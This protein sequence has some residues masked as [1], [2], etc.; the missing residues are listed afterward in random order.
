MFRAVVA[1]GVLVPLAAVA[2]GCRCMPPGE[3]PDVIRFPHATAGVDRCTGA[4]V[5]FGEVGAGNVRGR[6][7]V[8]FDECGAYKIYLQTLFVGQTTYDP[9]V[10]YS[11]GR[12]TR[13]AEGRLTLVD[14]DREGIAS[15]YPPMVLEAVDGGP[16]LTG[17]VDW[18]FGI[19]R[20]S[21]GIWLQSAS[22]GLWFPDYPTEED[23]AAP[24]DS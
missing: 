10:L 14:R 15:D 23:G 11:R 24:D 13:G 8:L 5:Y 7:F 17:R 22:F 3:S 12:A 18:K 20:I 16:V 21:G 9:Y 6:I 2:V 19:G 1:G 4:E